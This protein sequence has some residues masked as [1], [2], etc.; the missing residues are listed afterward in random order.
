M[1]FLMWGLP[2]ARCLSE[3]VLLLVAYRFGKVFL[4]DRTIQSLGESVL[5]FM[6]V[7]VI[8]IAARAR[9]LVT[10]QGKFVAQLVLRDVAV[11]RVRAVVAARMGRG[12]AAMR[13][14]AFASAAVR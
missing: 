6:V 12:V 7:T 5:I 8:S 2:E 11:G 9:A 10:F 13:G 4:F 3:V 1:L 14:V